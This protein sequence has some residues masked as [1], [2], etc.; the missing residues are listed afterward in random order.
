MSEERIKEL[1]EFTLEFQ[2]QLREAK[3]LYQ[4]NQSKSKTLQPKYLKTESV[5]TKLHLPNSNV[6]IKRIKRIK[7]PENLK[8]KQHWVP[9][10]L[11]GKSLDK[12]KKLTNKHFLTSW[13]IVNKILI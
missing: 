2:D 1:Q 10:S 12:F 8:M 6:H 3:E 4:Q 13:E 5:K 7:N 11:F 9:N